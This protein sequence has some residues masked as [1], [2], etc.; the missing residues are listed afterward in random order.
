M[1]RVGVSL[2]VVA[3]DSVRRRP[4]AAGTGTPEAGSLRRGMAA[5]PLP[6]FRADGAEPPVLPAAAARVPAPLARAGIR[7]LA[8]IAG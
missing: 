5:W 8:A 4:C 1:D 3:F 7:A 2:R 6:W